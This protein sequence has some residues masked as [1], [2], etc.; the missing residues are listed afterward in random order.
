MFTL[1]QE[2]RRAHPHF[3][4]TEW[5]FDSLFPEHRNVA[6][7]IKAFLHGVY[8]WFVYPSSHFPCL[9]LLI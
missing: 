4:G 2:V 5:M 8:N 1:H 3:Y 6:I 9:L 7:V